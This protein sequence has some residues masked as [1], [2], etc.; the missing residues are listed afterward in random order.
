MHQIARA[1]AALAALLPLL[2]G[3]GAG[4]QPTAPADMT[5]QKLPVVATFSIIADMVGR[6]GGERVAVAALVGPGGDAHTFEPTPADSVRL[7]GA[8]AVFENGLAFEPWL[9]DLYAASGSQA[10]R[11]VVSAGIEPLVAAAGARAGEGQAHG[12]LDPHIWH[13]V[14]NAMTMVENIRAGLAAADPAGAEVYRA[15]ANAY[16]AE[17]RELDAFV[18]AQAAQIPPERRKL[19]TTHDTFGYYARRYGFE[20]V[21]TALGAL[22]TEAADPPASAIAGL[23]EEIRAAGVPAIFAENVSTPG[24]MET[25]AREAGVALAP[26]LFTDALSAPGGAGATYVAMMRYNATTIAA[27]LRGSR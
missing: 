24:L 22:S 25:I 3:C 10:A 27:A 26:P 5:S 8:R 23:I 21:G 4:Q 17:L 13:D 6:V 11:V 20:V 1:L 7:A 2:A 12:E 18:Q 14:Q 16:L 15:N 19:V 9:G